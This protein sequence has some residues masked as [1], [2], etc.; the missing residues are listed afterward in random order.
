MR[1]RLLRGAEHGDGIVEGR[2]AGK[3]PRQ[4]AAET[5]VRPPTSHGAAQ[6]LAS[7]NGKLTTRILNEDGDENGSA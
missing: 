1:P 3:R 4:P 7:G 6:K 5:F 2:L